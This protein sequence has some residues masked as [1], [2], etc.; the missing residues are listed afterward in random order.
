MTEYLI[1]LQ[2]HNLCIRSSQ[3]VL[4][5]S[6]GFA[7]IAGPLPVFGE[8]ARSQA[9]QH[10]RHSFNNFWAQLGLDPLTIKNKHFRHNAD[11][12]YGHLNSLVSELNLQ[13]SAVLAVPAN[14]TRAQLA[15]LLGVA[16]QCAFTTV[17]LVDLAL[18]QAAG[19]VADYDSD[20]IIIDLQLH[21][22]VLTSFR[23]T[24]AHVVRDRVVQIPFAGLLA[25][26]D[27]WLNLITDEFIRQCRFDLQRDAESEQYIVNQLGAVLTTSRNHNELVLDI[28]LKGAVQQAH[29]TFHQFEQKALPVFARINQE[30]A[31]LRNPGTSVQVATE[32]VNLPGLTS[33]IAGLVAVDD[34]IAMNTLVRHFAHIKQ[35]TDNMQLVTRLPLDQA[36]A[37]GKQPVPA[38]MPTHVLLEHKAHALPTGRLLLGAAAAGI[39]SARIMP[40]QIEG[41]TGAIALVRSARGLQLELHT[42]T[43]VL[44]NGHSAQSGHMLAMGDTLVLGTSGFT[45]QLI[46]VEHGT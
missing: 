26:Q 25:L 20:C 6:P 24:G 42:T 46:V 38:R 1:E 3:Q 18:L 11:L 27:A 5:R 45:V 43:P 40:L 35:S 22:T 28:N 39:E 19:S 44:L 31:A 17:G 33:S 4:V 29:L 12:A 23:K 15:V 32:H 34:D 36:A 30:L 14:Y 8:A 21:Q 13:G 10:P 16:K 37:P 7:N 41:F 2:D 9:R